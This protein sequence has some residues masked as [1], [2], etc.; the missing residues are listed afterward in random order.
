MSP[1]LKKVLKWTAVVVVVLAVGAFLAFLYFIPP[2]LLTPPEQFGK[3][4]ANAAP[5]VS[6]IADPARRAIAERGPLHRDDDR[7]H[8]LPRDERPAGT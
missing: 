7:L 1:V 5:V 8:R 4:M 3:D 2:F 6:G